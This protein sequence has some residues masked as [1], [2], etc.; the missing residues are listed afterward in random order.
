MFCQNCGKEIDD[1]AVVCPACGVGVGNYFT[2]KKET[3]NTFAV[4]G[5]TLAFLSAIDEILCFILGYGMAKIVGFIFAFFIAMASLICSIIGC[6]TLS[7]FKENGKGLAMAGTIISSVSIVIAFI[8][9]IILS[10]TLIV[11]LT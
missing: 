4:I 8:F 3:I 9:I 11:V 7:Q 2:Q 10:N 1:K 5:F 6:K